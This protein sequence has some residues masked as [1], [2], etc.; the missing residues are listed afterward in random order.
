MRRRELAQGGSMSAGERRP[1]SK[2][3][4]TALMARASP[5][6]TCTLMTRACAQACKYASMRVCGRECGHI[7]LEGP[8]DERSVQT[9]F[10]CKR[11]VSL[12]DE[13]AAR[14]HVQ[15]CSLLHVKRVS[16]V[17]C[18]TADKAR[19]GA[20]QAVGWVERGGGRRVGG[21]SGL[22]TW[23]RERTSAREEAKAGR[24]ITRGG[25]SKGMPA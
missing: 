24:R 7:T 22:A 23:K 14:G 25:I 8:D 5:S 11:D 12:Q 9:H 18:G 15:L 6:S 20:T 10:A 19:R 1:A 16:H 13:A 3:Q 17:P 2:A 4:G 21:G